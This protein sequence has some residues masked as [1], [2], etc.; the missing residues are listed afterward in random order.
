VCV[1]VCVAAAKRIEAMSAKI[2]LQEN[3]AKSTANASLA[4]A[5][6]SFIN[7]VLF[8]VLITHGGQR[9]TLRE[10]IDWEKKTKTE[11]REARQEAREERRKEREKRRKER[12]RRR[13]AGEEV[14]P[15]ESEDD[16]TE[17]SSEEDDDDDDDD[18]D[19]KSSK[20][21][22]NGDGDGGGGDGDGDQEAVGD[23]DGQAGGYDGGAYGDGDEAGGLGGY[24]DDPHLAHKKKSMVTL[25]ALM[26]RRN[27][28]P[29][30][31]GSAQARGACDGMSV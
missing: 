6:A 13:K 26:A 30:A 31:R 4:A 8:T 9:I 23:F 1:W 16:R 29:Q 15:K 3:T 5:S 10:T 11:A 7:A 21:D 20:S 28:L 18:D 25:S 24:G 12:D 19:N 14:D 17:E 27:R 2:T 22:G